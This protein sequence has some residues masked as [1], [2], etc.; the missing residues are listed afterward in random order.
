[1]RENLDVEVLPMW[2]YDWEVKQL[3]GKKIALVNV[4][5][6]GS[7]GGSITWELENQMRESYPTLFPLDHFRRQKISK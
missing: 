7:I 3:R 5:W 6:G 2:I 4:V 1:M